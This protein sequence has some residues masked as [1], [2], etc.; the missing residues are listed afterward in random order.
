VTRMVS[1]PVEEWSDEARAVLPTY[2]RRP[3]LYRPGAPDA[4]PMPAA[5]GLLAHH[6]PLG[7]AWLEF[8][9]VLDKQTTLDL[10]L[11]ELIVLRVAWQTRSGYEWAQHT[12]MALHAGVTAEQLYAVP[13]GAGAAV[14]TP[15]ERALLTAADQMVERRRVDDRT[16]GELAEHFTDA[17]LLEVLFVAGAYL[18]FAV[19]TNSVDLE[20]DPPTEPVDAPALPPSEE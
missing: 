7:E 20:P 15:V 10:R 11:R 4:R 19:V 18:C 1:L 12:R 8:N 14:W 9:H 2:L 6:L 3:E 17:E 13:E 5:L 16:W